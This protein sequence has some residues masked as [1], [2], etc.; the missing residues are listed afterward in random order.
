VLDQRGE[1]RE[2]RRHGDGLK[3]F[4]RILDFGCGC[5]RGLRYL[6][7]YA[8]TCAIHGCDLRAE[9]IEWCVENLPWVK[10]ELTHEAPPLPYAPA[11]F[12]LIFSISVFSH[13]SEG[14]AREWIE[15]LRRVSA[16]GALVIVTTHGRH[17]LQ[18]LLNGKKKCEDF[19]VSQAELEAA[20][21]T[22]SEQGFVF[23]SQTLAGLNPSL[24]GMAFITREYVT[25]EW[26]AA[27][28]ILE[29]KEARVHDWQDVLVMRPR[30]Q[31]ARSAT[32]P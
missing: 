2:A 12:D 7:P 29:Y 5:G 27:F 28:E 18:Q 8:R 31:G 6:L 11:F 10:V 4:K 14:S 22:L 20:E 17:A 3:G 25:R 16:P 21:Q 26:N 23:L 24:Y 19:G 1:L 9:S 32:A 15:E 13:L 30:K